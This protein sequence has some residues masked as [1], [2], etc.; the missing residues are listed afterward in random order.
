MRTIR[1]RK[2]RKQSIS[3]IV[4]LFAVISSVF[5]IERCRYTEAPI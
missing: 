3:V 5:R 2:E 1:I 4:G